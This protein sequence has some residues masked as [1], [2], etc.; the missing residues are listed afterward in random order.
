MPRNPSCTLCP[1]HERAANV[2]IWGEWRLVA[3][4]GAIKHDTM[5]L[6]MAPG[7]HEDIEGRP[8][9]GRSGALLTDALRAAGIYNY[10]VT[11]TVKCWPGEENDIPR[12]AFKGVAT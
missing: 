7:A 8:F 4:E 12:E 5:V 10:Y 6:G 2:C 3:P 9:M 1:L 11:N